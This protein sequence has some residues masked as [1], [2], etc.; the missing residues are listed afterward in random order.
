MNDTSQ[1]KAI[2]S[3]LIKGELV[4]IF[5]NREFD[6]LSNVNVVENSYLIHPL[7]SKEHSK[8]LTKLRDPKLISKDPLFSEN[9]SKTIIV[10]YNETK[11]FLS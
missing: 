10:S 6:F 11:L 2:N 5:L 7:D 9:N 1:I 3:A 4:E 8:I